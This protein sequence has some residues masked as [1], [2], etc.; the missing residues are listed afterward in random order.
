MLYM[1]LLCSLDTIFPH[2][3]INL[4]QLYKTVKQN[5]DLLSFYQYYVN[6]LL[7]LVHLDR[8]ITIVPGLVQLPGGRHVIT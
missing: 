4:I 6:A 8:I 3:N 7:S 2:K 5:G 1:I